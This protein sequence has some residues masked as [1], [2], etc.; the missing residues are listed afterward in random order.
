MR[1]G[2]CCASLVR[3]LRD[4]PVRPIRHPIGGLCAG[5]RVAGQNNRCSAERHP[6]GRPTRRTCRTMTDTAES[7]YNLL[8][9]YKRDY[10]TLTQLHRRRV[11]RAQR[12]TVSATSIDP[13]SARRSPGCRAAPKPRPTRPSR[14]P[15]TPSGT[16]ARTPPLVRARYLFK[17]KDLLDGHHEELARITTSGARQGHRRGAR[18]DPALDR[19]RRDR[20]RHHQPDDGLQPRRRRG[21]EHR[22]GRRAPA[23]GRLCLHHARS[24]SRH[25]A[26]LVLALCASPPATPSWSRCPSAPR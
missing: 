11:G 20:G 16:G 5:A 22:R 8:E 19:E 6:A 7:T 4:R 12:P 13:A 3:P 17:I 26:V 21:Q 14:R 2:A 9:P 15:T 24:T 10:G 25:G 1:L 23:A 18:R